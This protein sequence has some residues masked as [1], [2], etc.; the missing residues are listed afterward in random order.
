MPSVIE[1]PP[2]KSVE[3]IFIYDEILDEIL[4]QMQ[5]EFLRLHYSDEEI[6]QVALENLHH[7]QSID[8]DDERWRQDSIIVWSHDIDFITILHFGFAV[9]EL[10]VDFSAVM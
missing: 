6:R 7:Y 5:L 10:L 1:Y 8:E 2:E 3:N 9:E 4:A